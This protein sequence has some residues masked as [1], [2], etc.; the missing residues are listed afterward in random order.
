MRFNSPQYEKD[1]ENNMN[2]I[3]VAIVFCIIAFITG[4]S[5]AFNII[6]KF[7]EEDRLFASVKNAVLTYALGTCFASV[8]TVISF[9]GVCELQRIL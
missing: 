8:F 7:I 4:L 2:T 9:I 5:L 6:P 3:I 1:L